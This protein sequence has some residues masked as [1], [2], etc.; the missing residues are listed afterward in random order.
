MRVISPSLDRELISEVVE[1]KRQM[2]L[3]PSVI[4]DDDIRPLMAKV[5]PAVEQIHDVQFQ[6]DVG[7]VGCS[8]LLY[9]QIS[10]VAQR[11]VKSTKS[12]L[13]RSG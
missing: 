10:A 6:V 1:V 4:R 12:V 5:S 7:E 2:A 11:K 9:E 8:N 13:S 3:L